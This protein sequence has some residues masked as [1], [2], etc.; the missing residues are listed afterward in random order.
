MF[1]RCIPLFVFFSAI[2]SFNPV[3]S[4]PSLLPF[5]ISP[6]ET[7]F[8]QPVCLLIPFHSSQTYSSSLSPHVPTRPYPHQHQF[9][10]SPHT[11][12]SSLPLFHSSSLSPFPLCLAPLHAPWVALFECLGMH[13]LLHAPIR[14]CRERGDTRMTRGD[15][16]KGGMSDS[17]KTRDVRR[18]RK[19]KR[20]RL[21]C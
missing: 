13:P 12:S 17:V 20:E 5:Y 10:I 14:K 1:I 3:S 16:I 21:R 8:L 19:T 2:S 15:A 11:V 7:L 18:R 6:P 4:I 9:P